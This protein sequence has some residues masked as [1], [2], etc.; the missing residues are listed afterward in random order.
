MK[1]SRIEAHEAVK[2]SRRLEGK[3]WD[4]RRKYGLTE[5]ASYGE[6][7]G[8]LMFALKVTTTDG[9]EGFSY[10][11]G[12]VHSGS[13]GMGQLKGSDLN[14]EQDIADGT[15]FARRGEQLR[16]AWERIQDEDLLN[17]EKLLPVVGGALETCLWD[18]KGK[19]AGLPAHQLVGGAGREWIKAYASSYT[20]VGSPEEYADHAQEC[21]EMGYPAYK[22]H[23]YR[24]LDP[25]T[26]TLAGRNLASP[27]YDIEVCRA[28][29]DRVGDRMELML[30]PDTAYTLDEAVRVGRELEKLRFKWF[31]APMNERE[32]PERYRELRAQVH[33]PICGPE[34]APGGIHARAEW[35]R[36][37]WTDILRPGGGFSEMLK[38]MAL[39][40]VNRTHCE[41]HGG[42]HVKVQAIAA[43]PET[44][45]EY[46]EMFLVTPG[47]EHLGYGFV[48]GGDPE[49]DKG[50]IRVSQ[51]PGMGFSDPLWEYA[52]ANSV[53]SFELNRT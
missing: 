51:A 4:I 20:D 26:M 52:V 46:Y 45:S 24:C 10:G 7:I 1:I 29:R 2:P 50:R 27:D 33:V 17:T 38:C 28:V 8:R 3:W 47:V 41:T 40:Q 53:R 11:G 25:R 37:G 36:N 21:L 32:L 6:T 31:E 15:A 44:V 9:L 22:I 13:F 39:A 12:G 14:R 23:T 18:L 42:G 30:D 43:V 19:R 16:K 5:T 35:L 34:S 48:P 49:F